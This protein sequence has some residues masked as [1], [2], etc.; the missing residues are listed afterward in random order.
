MGKNDFAV[1]QQEIDNFIGNAEACKQGFIP[2]F[3]LSENV[4]VVESVCEDLCSTSNVASN[5]RYKI[6]SIDQLLF[7]LKARIGG[8]IGGAQGMQRLTQFKSIDEA[9]NQLNREKYT[10]LCEIACE[11]SIFLRSYLIEVTKSQFI[12]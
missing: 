7:N 4:R 3:T 12:V 6:L 9:T 1:I 8:N 2:L 5:R 10:F 11:V